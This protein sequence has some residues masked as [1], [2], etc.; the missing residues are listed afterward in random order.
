MG[1][2]PRQAAEL[3]EVGGA[4]SVE[5]GACGEEEQALEKRVVYGVVEAARYAERGA[6]AEAREDVAYLR[7]AVE[8]QQALEVVL[9]ERHRHAH[10]HR[11]AAYEHEA[12]LHRRKPH[13]AEEEI[14]DADDAVD[15]GLGEHAGDEHGDRAGR[16]AVGVRGYRVEGEHEALA[17][18]AGEEQRE[19]EDH[20][21]VHA[22]RQ[23]RRD[24]R[25]VQRVALGVYQRGAEQH[26]ARA[27]GLL[28]EFF[29]SWSNFAE[30]ERRRAAQHLAETALVRFVRLQKADY[31][32]RVADLF[33]DA[34][35]FL[36][37]RFGC[38]GLLRLFARLRGE[39]AASQRLKAGR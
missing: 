12:G 19:G 10:E 8:G 4:G 18:E 37:K 21:R 13:A 3:F 27:D 31:E 14:A 16:C 25:E 32:L 26:A 39:L 6:Q 38:S 2:L 17:A 23:E 15:A 28:E 5:H 20:R 22:P 33:V 34:A 29:Q 35:F 11:D 9:V 30:G 7:D 1:H 36:T 24:L